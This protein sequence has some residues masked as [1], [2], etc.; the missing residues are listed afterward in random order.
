MVNYT[1]TDKIDQELEKKWDSFVSS[2]KSGSISQLLFWR[3]LHNPKTNF[4]LYFWGEKSGALKIVALIRGRKLPVFGFDFIIERGPVCDD[5]EILIEGVGVLLSLLKKKAPIRLRLNPYFMEPV[6]DKIE[7]ELQKLHFVPF[8]RIYD[9]Y[10]RTIIVDLSQDESE[11]LKNMRRDTRSRIK[12]AQ[13]RG[14]NVRIGNS[15]NDLKLFYKLF[16]EM[17][18]E[19]KM[20]IPPH[21]F[22]KILWEDALK[23]QKYGALFLSYLK[24]TLLSSIIITLEG[25][26]AVY[27]WGASSR[28]T[29]LKVSKNHLVLWEAMLWAKERGYEFFDMGG[30]GGE[31]GKEVG[32]A[33][34]DA[35][36]QGFGGSVVRLVRIHKYPYRKVIDSLLTFLFPRK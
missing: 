11:L 30:I 27:S 28:Q 15:E 14:V 12:Q 3:K 22:F 21:T 34:V 20:S 2:Q 5:P 18:Q 36:K 7:K 13:K 35:F 23:D 4:W 16:S 32:L 25:R 10:Y 31:E 19:K 6:S 17:A 9:Q 8:Q 33:G 1:L 29:G 26:K 24:D